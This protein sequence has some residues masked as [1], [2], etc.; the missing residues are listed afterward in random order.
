MPSRETC[1]SSHPQYRQTGLKNDM[2]VHIYYIYFSGI[3]A[4][5]ELCD[6]PGI[7][8]CN[9]ACQRSQ[10]NELGQMSQ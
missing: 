2:A 3:Q 6:S 10:D 1:Q 9:D 5:V 4:G 8:G 7:A